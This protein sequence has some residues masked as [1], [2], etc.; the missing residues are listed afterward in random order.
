M[1]IET[2]LL[3]E[4]L[5]RKA[6]LLRRDPG[7]RF[8]VLS[9]KFKITW[10]CNLRCGLCGLWRKPEDNNGINELPAELVMSA[11]RELKDAGL[12]KLHYS[13]GEALLHPNLSELVGFSRS[14]DLQTNISTNGTLIDKDMARFLVDAK[15]HAINISIDSGIE[16][17]H[18][19]MRG[20]KN[21]W[22]RAWDGIDNLIDRR[23]AK[24]KKRPI[25]SIN[26][27][28][29]R[30]SAGTLEALHDMALER[31]VDNWRLLGVDTLEKRNRPTEG[32]WDELAVKREEWRSVLSRAPIDWCS[33]RGTAM[34]GKGKYAGKF[35]RERVCFAPWF[36]VFVDADGAVYPC[37][38][39]KNDMRPYGNIKDDKISSLLYSDVA[40][41]IRCSM[42]SG[43]M[44]P[45]CGCCDDFMEENLAFDKLYKKENL[46]ES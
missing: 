44:Y 39:G 2:L 31:G 22:R 9:A 6:L 15:V 16:K 45:I 29:T 26:T 23:R 20:V 33:D 5:A 28:V 37:C 19:S 42:A 25:V 12:R 32:Q 43:H 30:K 11:V 21:S 36:N 38:M 41:E 10:K 3:E 24:G 34:A 18:D 40:S 17:V 4:E 7:A 35:Y 1:K 13:G 27:L 46:N 8:P 14:L